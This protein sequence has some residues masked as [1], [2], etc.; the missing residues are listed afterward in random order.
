MGL[1]FF[2]LGILT[3]IPPIYGF[4]TSGYTEIRRFPLAILA[5]GLMIL[6]FSSAFLGI[7]LHSINYRFR[8]LHNIITR[9]K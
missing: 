7:L 3:G 6:A 2:V 4:V 9:H 8:E 5:T 1:I